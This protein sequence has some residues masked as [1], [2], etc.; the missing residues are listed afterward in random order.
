MAGTLTDLHD[1]GIS[2]ADLQIRIQQDEQLKLQLF[3]I[4]CSKNSG[5]EMNFSN[6]RDVEDQNPQPVKLEI[7]SSPAGQAS[8]EAF[9][10]AR[11]GQFVAA[12]TLKIEGQPR[13]VVAYRGSLSPQPAGPLP[14]IVKLPI[15]EHAWPFFGSDRAGDWGGVPWDSVVEVPFQLNGLTNPHVYSFGTGKSRP[16][17]LVTC[18]NIDTDGPGG[19]RAEDPDWAPE[20][21]L[22]FP[23]RIPCNSRK[24]PGVVR[25]IRLLKTFGLR[26]GDFGL[27]CYGGNVQEFQVFDQGQDDKIGEISIYLARQLGTVPQ[28]R[29]D[30]WAAT[31][32]NNT[33]QLVTLFFPQSGSGLAR[34]NEVIHDVAWQ[35]WKKFTGRVETGPAPSVPALPDLISKAAALQG[36][37]R[38]ANPEPRI[39]SSAEWGA[40]AARVA[41]FPSKP[42][43]GIVLH[44]TQDTNR[45]AQSGD[46]EVQAA[47]QLA[48]RTQR[49]HMGRGWSDTGQHFTISRG[50]VI[51]EGRDG[52]LSAARRGEVVRGAHA[53]DTTYNNEWFGI[54]IEGDFRETLAITAEQLNAL[55]NVCAWLRSTGGFDADKLIAH[56]QIHPGHTDCPGLLSQHLPDVRDQISSR[57]AQIVNAHGEPV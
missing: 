49:D 11:G 39:F 31:E 47:F 17:M 8:P 53:D 37:Q 4:G 1:T 42:A 30:H 12:A 46:L 51:M 41:Q 23:G 28:D 40:L 32:G 21:S 5:V 45:A 52:S 34:E 22:K 14:P 3:E 57:L 29:D 50:G 18:A 13:L 9:I 56:M 48:R 55:F 26:I 35:C 10:E 24:F 27:A 19:S 15:P 44:N 38:C 33:S 25:S 7:I 54:E 16:F 6:Y 2:L 20:T 36:D 43:R